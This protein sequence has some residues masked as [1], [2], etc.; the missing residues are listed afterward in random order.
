[1]HRATHFTPPPSKAGPALAEQTADHSPHPRTTSPFVPR[2]I[3][4]DGSPPSRRPENTAPDTASPPTKPAEAGTNRTA[5]PSL[6]TGGN[7][8]ETGAPGILLMGSGSISFKMEIMT[9]FPAKRKISGKGPPADF[10]MTSK[11]PQT[12]LQTSSAIS[13]MQKRQA[14]ILPSRSPP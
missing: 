1:M 12:E 13:R 7:E 14:F 5:E 4:I 8:R 6:L 2:S 11:R 3:S 10:D 9:V